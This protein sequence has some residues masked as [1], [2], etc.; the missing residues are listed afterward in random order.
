MVSEKQR[1]VLLSLQAR[2][3]RLASLKPYGNIK[4]T[5]AQL[6]ALQAGYTEAK[7]SPLGIPDRMAEIAKSLG[8]K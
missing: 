6:E 1:K 2:C 4:L 8:L 3:D 7:A 5:E